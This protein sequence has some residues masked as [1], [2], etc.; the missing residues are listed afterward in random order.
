MSCKYLCFPC[1]KIYQIFKAYR[2]KYHNQYYH[3]DYDLTEIEQEMSHYY[4]DL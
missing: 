2:D 4:N 3:P 1:K